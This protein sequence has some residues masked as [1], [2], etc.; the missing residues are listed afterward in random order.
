MAGSNRRPLRYKHNALTNWAKGANNEN[1]IFYKK[2]VI[3]PK[4]MLF[5]NC[6]K[7]ILDRSLNARCGIRTHEAYALVLKTNPFDHSGNLARGGTT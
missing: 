2:Y 6:C 3:L 5:N 1:A 7:K 4:N